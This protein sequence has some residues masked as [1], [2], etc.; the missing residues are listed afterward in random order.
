MVA[1]KFMSV[2]TAMPR[3]A[4]PNTAL[5]HHRHRRIERYLIAAVMVYCCF[6]V[7]EWTLSPPSSRIQ[8]DFEPKSYVQLER[9]QAVKKEFLHAWDGYR[10]HSWMADGLLPLT[11][12]RK[13]QFCSWSATMVDALDTLWIMD[14]TE[15]FNYAINGTMTIDFRSSAE[16]CEV[17]LF[18]STI[19]YLG[20][21]LGAYDLSHEP[22]LLAK[23]VEVGDLLH[24]AFK[25][26]NGMPCSY[27]HL[28][29]TDEAFFPSTNVAMADVGS[30]YL[31]FSRLSQL[32]GDP[33]YQRTVDHVLDVFQRSVNDSSIP[34]L[35][36]EMVDSSSIDSDDATMQRHF[37]KASYV[38]S[39][40]ALS[41]SSYEYLVK[42]HLML[43]AV[44]STYEDLWTTASDQ[45]RN[46]MLFR[47]F[48]PGADDETRKILFSGIISRTPGMT[49]IELEPR[50]QHLACFAGGMFAM[51]SRIFGNGNDFEIGKQ[52]TQGCVW[53]YDNSPTGL[54][55]E[56]VTLLPC[57]ELDSDQCEWNATT[58][59]SYSLNCM[60]EGSCIAPGMPPGWMNVADPKYI[61]R[62]EAIESVFIM[63]RMTGD[64]Y[65][66]D[67]GWRM[68]NTIIHHTRTPYGHSAISSVLY[69]SEAQVYHE[70]VMVTTQRA[71]QTDDMES[72]W[73]AETLKYFY[74]LFSDVDLVSLDEFVLNTEAHPFRLVDSLRGF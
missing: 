32:T 73:F 17:S 67:V 8:Y 18:E 56:T 52:L 66:R 10:D 59:E 42:G 29:N 71:M 36:P 43:G 68:F 51:A 72:F 35:W 40:G 9:Q 34:G 19:R 16:M 2:P 49:E 38:Y 74:L 31:E 65:W 12:G 33:K 28:A 62:P 60:S 47:S 45:I 30:L 23:M 58:W 37:A 11:G 53:A 48:I 24:G 21:L 50:T 1:G 70:G 22:R 55:P 61:L 39:L 46:F 27:C 41:D 5:S 64:E 20:G 26:S 13:T 7:I 14:L 57:P 69:Q 3:W 63:W 44:N 54:M 25:T 4:M 6:K 15:E